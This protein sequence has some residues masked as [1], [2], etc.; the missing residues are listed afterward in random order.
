M[1]RW[2]TIKQKAADGR[3]E[4]KARSQMQWHTD[5]RAASGLR[6]RKRSQSWLACI[7]LAAG[8]T[9]GAVRVLVRTTADPTT[10]AGLRWRFHSSCMEPSGGRI[11]AA[12]ELHTVGSG[13]RRE[14]SDLE[15]LSSRTCGRRGEK[16]SE[17]D[18]SG[19]T[20]S[21]CSCLA[22]EPGCKSRCRG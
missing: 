11:A 2:R 9:H 15:A 1:C 10:I 6:R 17:H 18:L 3:W 5:S 7:K 21:F 12:E 22:S 13:T 20:R 16:R 8:H 14:R 19:R 4:S